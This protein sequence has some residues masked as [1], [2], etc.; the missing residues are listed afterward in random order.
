[1]ELQ[2][3][4]CSQ[5]IISSLIIFDIHGIL[6]EASYVVLFTGYY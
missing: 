4:C 6:L 5:D 2:T 3:L 1:V